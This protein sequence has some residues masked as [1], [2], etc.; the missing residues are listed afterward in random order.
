MYHNMN[1]GKPKFDKRLNYVGVMYW[2]ML[3]GLATGWH[4]ADNNST[5]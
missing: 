1:H 5:V 4:A 3:N 2:R